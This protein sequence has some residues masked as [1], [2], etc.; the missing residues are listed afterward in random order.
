MLAEV[1][2][3]ARQQSPQIIM[4]AALLAREDT[5]QVSRP[6]SRCQRF[7]SVLLELSDA[8][9]TSPAAFFQFEKAAS[10]QK[11]LRKWIDAN[12]YVGQIRIAVN[13]GCSRQQNWSTPQF[14]V[15]GLTGSG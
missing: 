14:P 11:T 10:D 13:P 15:C 6:A 2:E 7:Q 1:M 4:P 8:L 9:G 5:I 12:S 3:R